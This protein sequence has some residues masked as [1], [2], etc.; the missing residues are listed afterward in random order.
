MARKKTPGPTKEE[1]V[2]AAAAEVRDARLEQIAELRR[3]GINPYP[4][5]FEITHTSTQFREGYDTPEYETAKEALGEVDLKVPIGQTLD[6]VV[7]LGGQVTSL[8]TRPGIILATV[9]QDAASTE[10][11][12]M[13]KKVGPAEYTALEQ[14]LVEGNYIGVQGQVMR[15]RKGDLGVQVNA[16]EVLTSPDSYSAT[17]AIT[18]FIEQYD[19]PAYH[20]A[21]AAVDAIDL[22]V[23]IGTV[24][25]KQVTVAGKVMSSRA[26]GK[27]LTFVTIQDQGGFMQLVLN[28]RELGDEPYEILT[29]LVSSGDY[30]G[31]TGNVMR[32]KAGELSVQAKNGKILSKSLEP[33][34]KQYVVDGVDRKGAGEVQQERE[35]GTVVGGVAD[36]NLLYRRPELRLAQS[37]SERTPLEKRA[38]AIS[39]MREILERHR[40][41]DVDS[42]PTLHEIYGGAF[43]R[44]FQTE[45]TLG[46]DRDGK[47]ITMPMVLGVAP[48]IYLKRMLAAGYSNGVYSIGKNFRD[49][50]ADGTHNPEFT[51]MECYKAFVDYNWLMG[52][53]ENM[54]EEIFTRVNGSSIVTF[55]R[56]DLPLGVQQIDVKAGWPRKPVLELIA[57]NTVSEAFQHGIDAGSMSL[58]DLRQAIL[59]PNADGKPYLPNDPD[60]NY[61]EDYSWGGLVTELFGTYAENTIVQPTFAIDFPLETTPLCKSHRSG[62]TRL[63]EKFEHFFYGTEG[64]N[65]Y[66]E[67]NDPVRQRELFEAQARLGL[68]E[69]Q[70]PDLLDE[71][72]IKAL[73]LGMPLA[74][75]LGIGIDRMAML[76]TGCTTIKE[77]LAFPL[78]PYEGNMDEFRKYHAQLPARI[79]DRKEA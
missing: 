10:L 79:E 64:S 30:I 24:S 44:P 14:K 41:M 2:A 34:P 43:A 9:E 29:D 62:D 73:E 74:G 54:Y 26:A 25:D 7:D 11:V 71:R 48:E 18:A 55:G 38:K 4:H 13:K 78:V 57:K 33:L 17:H 75:G 76:L 22:K 1:R 19:T 45:L 5:T 50:N 69:G 58:D 47:D 66:T 21:R 72:F 8:I 36:T 16:A 15:T 28:K 20:E 60:H 40:Y 3:R 53:V 37:P 52:F 12:F 39:I 27:K 70:S 65:A 77:V 56:P 23:P 32:T 61:Q 35:T 67:L 49:E 31:V 6:D 46:K 63:V 68:K 59:E 51:A 42:I